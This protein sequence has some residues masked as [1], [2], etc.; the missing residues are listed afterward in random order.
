MDETTNTAV[1]TTTVE[2]P[3]ENVSVPS[4]ESEVPS[5]EPTQSNDIKITVDGN[6]RRTLSIDT[7][8]S[9]LIGVPDQTK[10]E[11]Q[12]TE[13]QTEVV[14]PK[15]DEVPTDE[16][17]YYANMDEF[18]KA[19]SVGMLDESRVSPEQRQVLM[20]LAV[21]KQYEQQQAQQQQQLQ[22]Q[23]NA[24]IHRAFKDITSKTR[25]D[26]MASL[27]ISEDDFKNLEFM[28]NGE[29]LRKRFQ[30]SYETATMD[31]LKDYLTKVIGAEQRMS[32]HNNCVQ[33][34]SR[35]CM[36]EQANEPNFQEIVAMMDNSKNDMPYG[37]AQKIIRAENNLRNHMATAS[38]LSAIREYYDYCKK[39]VYQQKA[40]VSKVPQRTTAPKVENVSQP[41]STD[42]T[43]KVD[44]AAMRNMTSYQRSKAMTDL[45][46]SLM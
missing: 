7:D 16:P 30:E 21:Q 5:N 6:G 37:Q 42:N 17:Q 26:V 8:M 33:E 29:E 25:A 1:E 10:Q 24:E 23:R 14:E 3:T 22:A 34:I 20:N 18:V 46:A 9:E 32:E 36:A 38:D 19:A 31:R 35:F 2:T 13:E 28:D 39:A 44:F 4:T 12:P 41:T 40:G 43:P 45:I 11:E 27:N 15:V